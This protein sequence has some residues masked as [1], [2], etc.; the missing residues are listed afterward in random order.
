VRSRE[1]DHNT[2]DIIGD[3]HGQADKLEALL[4]KL[5]YDDTA[6]AWRHSERKAIFVG[7]FVDRGPAQVRSVNIARRMVDAG[8]ALAVMG[9]HE[10]NAIAW[11][12]P[13]PRDPGEY[14]RP[15]NS[16]KWGRKNRQQHAAFLAEVEHK[17]ALHAEVIDW[18]LTL[19]LWIDL[20]AFRV[21][22]ACW[23]APFLAWLKPRLHHERYLTR[24]LMV[25]AT[26]EP[27]DEAEKDNATPSMFKAVEALTK[28]IEVPLPPGHAFS[29][30]DGHTRDRVR[31]R[32]WDARATS[33]REAAM[34]SA[35]EASALPEVAIPGH[36]RI[37]LDDRLVFF[38]HYWLTGDIALQ[39]PRH[40]CVDYSA[41]N[42]GPL[43]AYRYD[44]ESELAQEKFVWVD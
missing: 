17:P 44:G 20:P 39:S 3:I 38:G 16:P 6:G 23:H 27:I 7:D 8:A 34:L 41:G 10:L 21:V 5:G 11:H 36:A 26:E 9:N 28:G 40:A 32:W 15:R 18:F 42:G 43:V 25:A 13:D 22:H 14:L 33:Y 12:T 24:D 29:D 4:R 30:K 35:A 37:P 1:N 19:P 31:V 2:F